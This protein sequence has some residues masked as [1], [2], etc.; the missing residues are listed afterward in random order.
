MP[1]IRSM[2]DGTLSP[3]LA[4]VGLALGAAPSAAADAP[5]TATVL[6]VPPF[7]D[8]LDLSSVEKLFNSKKYRVEVRA[9]GAADFTKCHV[10]ETRNDWVLLDF[11]GPDK[12]RVRHAADEF[13]DEKGFMRT[14]SF[15]QFSFADTAVDVRVTL[16]DPATV[17]RT[18]TVRPLRHAIAATIAGDGRSFTFRLDR[19]LKVSIDVNDRL[20]PLF[21]FDDAPDVPDP[22][23]TYFFGPGVH[24]L[25]GDGR[26]TL[27]SNERVYLAAG[28]I[29]EGRFELAR[30]SENITIR[31]RGILSCGEWPHV[32]TQPAWLVKNSTFYSAG[33]HHFTLEGLT[34]VQGSGWT[35]AIDDNTGHDTH[36]NRYANVKMVHWAGNTDAFWIT[37]RRNV[38]ED[39]FVFNNDDAIVSK[40][41]G[42]CRVSDLVVWGGAWGRL[43]LFFNFG[44]PIERILIENVDVIGKGET[45]H[46]IIAERL[47]RSGPTELRDVTFRNVRFEDRAAPTK[48]NPGR[49]FDLDA[50]AS[51]FRFENLRFEGVTLDQQFP[52]EGPIAGTAE[53]PAAGVAFVGLRMGGREID[54]AEAGHL[55]FNEHVSGVKFEPTTRP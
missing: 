6:A 49:L 12:Q 51:L 7:A 17:A 42:D 48:K 5:T 2:V 53:Q 8:D 35:V 32:S 16:L 19:P 20:D 50:Q 15:A 47:R 21:L 24:R 1:S 23:A 25:P 38:V 45:P 10:F 26:L 9:A 11:F 13:G 40:G 52:D 14:A 31:G 36:D 28:A 54:S 18:V 43:A 55:L 33:T 30:G 4:S 44:R 41:G 46:F 29:V 39:C 3:L 34:L 37:G 27:K 22:Q